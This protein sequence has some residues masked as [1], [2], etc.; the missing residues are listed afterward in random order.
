MCFHG[1]CQPMFDLCRIVKS[2]ICQRGMEIKRYIQYE[3]AMHFRSQRLLIVFGSPLIHDHIHTTR[4]RAPSRLLWC[5]L[6][7]HGKRATEKLTVIRQT[8]I[9]YNIIHI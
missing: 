6:K 1:A 3:Y 5:F 7:G 4:P 2:R 8:G 9:I